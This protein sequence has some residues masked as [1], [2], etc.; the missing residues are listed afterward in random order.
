MNDNITNKYIMMH[1]TDIFKVYM[2]TKIKRFQEKEA[3]LPSVW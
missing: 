1:T 2:S 3:I